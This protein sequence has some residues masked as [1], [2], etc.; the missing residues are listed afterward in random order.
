MADNITALMVMI[1]EQA[2]RQEEQDRCLEE[3]LQW[4][5]EEQACRQIAD[6][7]KALGNLKANMF[8]TSALHVGTAQ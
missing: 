3:Q 5:Q 4:D 6:L 7:M 2:H 8:S 1:Q